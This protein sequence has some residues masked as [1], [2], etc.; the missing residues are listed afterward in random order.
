[1]AAVQLLA[2]TARSP[3]TLVILK[4]TNSGSSWSALPLTLEARRVSVSTF[5][6]RDQCDNL[7]WNSDRSILAIAGTSSL[8]R[9]VAVTEAGADVLRTTGGSTITLNAGAQVISVAW[10]PRLDRLYVGLN[11]SPWLKVYTYN[12]S[13]RSFTNVTFPNSGSAPSAAPYT[14]SF[15]RS[16][17]HLA[18]QDTGVYRISTTGSATFQS[19]S[20]DGGLGALTFS[21]NGAYLIS[22]DTIYDYVDGGG[23]GD[24]W[25]LKYN[26]GLS[27]TIY[28]TAFNFDSTRVLLS[29]PTIN[30][31]YNASDGTLFQTIDPATSGYSD[32]TWETDGLGFLIGKTNAG[33]LYR[34]RTTGGAYS[35]STFNI[36]ELVLVNTAGTSDLQLAPSI[37]SVVFGRYVEPGYGAA[38]YFGDGSI[39]GLNN[40]AV[41]GTLAELG[42][43]AMQA[44]S[45]VSVSAARTRGGQANLA[46]E[47]AVS[48]A[49]GI[50]QEAAANL[51][52]T[53]THTVAADLTRGGSA[54]LISNSQ[55]SAVAGRLQSATT[56]ISGSA[57]VTPTAQATR[58][59]A[60]TITAQATQSVQARVDYNEILAI[61]AEA[62]VSALAQQTHSPTIA[63]SGAAQFVLSAD[64]LVI[65][66]A[67]LAAQFQF[68]AAATIT[69][70]AQA[71]LAT[72]AT[73][74]AEARFPVQHQALADLAGAV[75]QSTL[76][77]R[78]I[79]PTELYAYSWDDLSQWVEWPFD[80][81][82]PRGV[83]MLVSGGQLSLAG[84]TPAGAAALTAQANLAAVAGYQLSAQA[85]VTVAATLASGSAVARPAEASLSTQT[86]LQA[87]GRRTQDIDLALFDAVTVT[88]TGVMVTQ[89]AA[90]LQSAASAVVV[91]AFRPGGSAAITS[92]ATLAAQGNYLRLA[93]ANFQALAAALTVATIFKVDN[94]RLAPVRPESRVWTVPEQTRQAPV[95]LSQRQYR[96]EGYLV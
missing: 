35:E 51:A 47:A 63:L 19:G 34:G 22:D 4:S 79:E 72:Q 82:E 26:L 39:V 20:P 2:L 65:Q 81:W 62:A 44:V 54:A 1:M 61:A 7:S 57:S 70:G 91:P 6:D 15:T 56:A 38:G 48:A 17:S 52:S 90:A 71:T 21:P 80:E 66:D 83:F 78:L 50:I 8:V 11:A 64:V 46:A 68:S 37:H 18:V 10:H 89:G 92:S 32:I 49:A 60:S 25:T 73:L 36:P 88:A 13:T 67:L 30:Y 28:R 87:Q 74:A 53:A 84:N 75:T 94:Y 24:S 5:A 93:E 76:G 86:Q 40:F 23:L 69:A 95:T 55:I 77:G 42:E 9:F 58:S 45:T 96:V 14:L 33:T 3:D 59:A 12:R 29:A 41:S 85:A 31:V 16:G 43:V 27:P